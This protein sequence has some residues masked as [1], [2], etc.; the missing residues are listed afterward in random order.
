MPAAAAG[1]VD[2]RGMRSACALTLPNRPARPAPPPPPLPV[3][4]SRYAE[5]VIH[6]I[7]YHNNRLGDGRIAWRE[8]RR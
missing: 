2:G 5:T 8:F 3:I 7:F 4:C 1:F 6:R